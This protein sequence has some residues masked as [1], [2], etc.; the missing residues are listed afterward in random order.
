[1]R[2]VCA[3][4]TAGPTGIR[5]RWKINDTVFPDCPLFKPEYST[6]WAEFDLVAA[7][8]L[9]DEIGLTERDGKGLRLLPEREV[10]RNRIYSGDTLMSVWGGLEN[11]LPTPSMSPAG[12]APT[13]Q[14]Q[15]QWP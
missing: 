5:S 2:P 13:R 15:Y 3:K 9:L 6:A 14:D 8:A 1:M 4:F 10:F 7:N 11:S 12:L